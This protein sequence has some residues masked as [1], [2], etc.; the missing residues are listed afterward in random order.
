[1][2]E[3]IESL[4]L[5]ESLLLTVIDT[6]WPTKCEI[7]MNLF[8]SISQVSGLLEMYSNLLT[9][10]TGLRDLSVEKT[11]ANWYVR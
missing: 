9:F 10:A 3:C 6:L 8:V 5:K 4:D 2:A 11:W 1:M 7:L